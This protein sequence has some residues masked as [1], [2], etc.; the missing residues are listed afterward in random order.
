MKMEPS[1]HPQILL[2]RRKFNGTIGATVGALSSFIGP[3]RSI[4]LSGLY[5][6]IDVTPFSP[7]FQHFPTA[8]TVAAMTEDEP[9]VESERASHNALGERGSAPPMRA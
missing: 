5:K 4:S 2:W 9:G 3:P 6:S 8:G 7:A 1:A